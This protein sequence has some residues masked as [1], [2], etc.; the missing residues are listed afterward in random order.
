MVQAYGHKKY[1]DTYNYLKGMEVTRNLSCALR[2]IFAYLDR[3]D[4]D[5]ESGQSHLAH[6]TCR[7]LFAIQNI[8]DGTAIDDRRP[9]RKTL[10][11]LRKGKNRK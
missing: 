9:A 1:G 2:H 7:L 10:Q 4:I 5:K 6:A 3:D 8:H 11:V